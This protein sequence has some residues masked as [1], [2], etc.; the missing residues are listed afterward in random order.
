VILHCLQDHMYWLQAHLIS[1][2]QLHRL[3]TTASMV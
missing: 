1:T 3:F 2:C